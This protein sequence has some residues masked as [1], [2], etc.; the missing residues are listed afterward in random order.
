LLDAADQQVLAEC[1]V[2]R[3]GW[4]LEA[5]N[6]VLGNDPDRSAQVASALE[7]LT[8]LR[9]RSLLQVGEAPHFPGELRFRLLESIREFAAKELDRTGRRELVE[10]RHASHFVATGERW[11]RDAQ[12]SGEAEAL[13]RLEL[14]MDNLV[15]VHRA[16][17]G[18]DDEAVARTSL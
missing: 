2:F 16:S 12:G 9:D 14:E 13:R 10:K 6:S 1:S 18:R 4:S 17:G 3:G 8:S 5:A 11:A 15:A 7:H